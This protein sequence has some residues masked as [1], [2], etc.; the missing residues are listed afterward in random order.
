MFLIMFVYL[1]IQGL[2]E[3]AE[4]AVLLGYPTLSL[5]VPGSPGCTVPQ[6]EVASV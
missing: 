2:S 5:K 1:L 3:K 4:Q 6:A